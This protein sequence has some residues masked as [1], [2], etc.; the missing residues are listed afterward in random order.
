MEV[1]FK[2]FS[3]PS[4]TVQADSINSQNVRSTSV[5][6]RWLCGIID[7]PI[8]PN[9]GK[10]SSSILTQIRPGSKIYNV[11]RSNY[12]LVKAT[13]NLVLD[14]YVYGDTLNSESTFS[15]HEITDA[16]FNQDRIYYTNSNVSFDPPPIATSAS[17]F[18]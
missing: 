14:Y 5:G 11:N 3:I 8:D 2:E 6:D 4:V 15:L 10:I 9:F 1:R 13:L 16:T 17:Q 7:N 18:K 12:V